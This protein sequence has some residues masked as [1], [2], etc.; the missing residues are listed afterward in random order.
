MAYLGEFRIDAKCGKSGIAK[1]KKCKK[2]NQ[3]STFTQGN[4][5][6]KALMGAGVAASVGGLG[7]AA[8]DIPKDIPFSTGRGLAISSGGMALMGTGTYLTGR[9]TGNKNM[10]K[11]GRNTALGATAIGAAHLATTSRRVNKQIDRGLESFGRTRPGAATKAFGNKAF[12]KTVAVTKRA[13]DVA[14][15]I[16]G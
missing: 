10:E 11:H 15:R 6:E 9:R 2:G 12:H 13:A 4:L 7:K 5:G 14:K 8:W 16:R 1:G 3:G